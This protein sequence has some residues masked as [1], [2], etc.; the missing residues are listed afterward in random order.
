MEKVFVSR[1]RGNL[2]DFQTFLCLMQMSRFGP[3]DPFTFIA[4]LKESQYSQLILFL[5]PV[6]FL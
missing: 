6:V 3:F 1:M 2:C 5:T 4:H